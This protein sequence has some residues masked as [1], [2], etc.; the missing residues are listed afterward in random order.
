M[1]IDSEPPYTTPSK[2]VVVRCT[3]WLAW[4]VD[5]THAHRDAGSERGHACPAGSF[6]RVERCPRRARR[7]LQASSLRALG[8]GS[9]QCTNACPRGHLA[10]VRLHMHGLRGRYVHLM[11]ASLGRSVPHCRSARAHD[12]SPARRERA[13][14]ERCAA[15]ADDCASEGAQST[16]QSV[17]ST[18][19]MNPTIPAP[20][21]AIMQLLVEL[22]TILIKYAFKISIQFWSRRDNSVVPLA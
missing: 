4:N 7:A 19:S 21:R 6:S 2:K 18:K 14:Q 5:G 16:V 3:L 17:Y 11:R 22:S 9:A 12:P 20:S 10:R 1:G 13:R 15:A 8:R